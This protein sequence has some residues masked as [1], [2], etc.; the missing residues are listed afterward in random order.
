[1]N[2]G[3]YYINNNYKDDPRRYLYFNLEV[4]FAWSN[5]PGGSVAAG[6]SFHDK[7]VKGQRSNVKEKSGSLVL[8]VWCWAWG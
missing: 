4:R 1:M 6:R 7:K 5:N 3:S 2:K 8:Q